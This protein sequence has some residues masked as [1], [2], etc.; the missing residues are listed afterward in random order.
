MASTKIYTLFAGVNGAGKSTLFSVDTAADLGSVERHPR[1]VFQCGCA[2][3]RGARKGLFSFRF[4]FWSAAPSRSRVARAKVKLVLCQEA[5]GTH[6]SHPM[7]LF[8]VRLSA[9]ATDIIPHH[10]EEIK[11]AKV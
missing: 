5:F 10:P 6:G 4:L 8:S 7:Q 9:S 11:R 1:G 2:H 3:R